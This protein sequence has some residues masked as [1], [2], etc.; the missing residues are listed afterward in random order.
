M[1]PNR[2]P[3]LLDRARQQET[4]LMAATALL[5]TPT[6]LPRTARLY[7]ACLCLLLVLLTPLASAAQ[8]MIK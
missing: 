4:L 3:S 1:M 2:F 7:M 5:H 6:K 8:A